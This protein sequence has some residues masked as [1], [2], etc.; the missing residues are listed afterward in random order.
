MRAE[1]DT[2]LCKAYA[3]CTFE[4]PEVFEVD[5]TTGKAHILVEGS[6]E[7]RRD[8]VERAVDACPVGAIRLT[9]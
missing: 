7:S 2:M 8:E 1:V 9:K 6:L 3:N 5:E 4:A